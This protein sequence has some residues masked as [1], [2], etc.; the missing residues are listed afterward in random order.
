MIGDDSVEIIDGKL[1]PIVINEFL[2]AGNVKIQLFIYRLVYF[3][4]LPIVLDLLNAILRVDIQVPSE[5]ESRLVLV[6]V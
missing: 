2:V 6:L 4:T 5:Y 1:I 3:L